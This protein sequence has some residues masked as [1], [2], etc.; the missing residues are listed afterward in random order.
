[1]TQETTFLDRLKQSGLVDNL[2]D[3]I[4]ASILQGLPNAEA[5]SSLI[6]RGAL[7]EYQAGVLLNNEDAPLLIDEYEVRRLIGRGGMGYVLEAWHRK[8][9]RRVAI[10]LLLPECGSP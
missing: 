7:T 8:M 5:A 6:E 1:M 9:K 2:I 3:E 10:K 4:E